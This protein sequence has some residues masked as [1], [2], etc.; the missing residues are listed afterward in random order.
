LTTSRNRRRFSFSRWSPTR[1]DCESALR[2]VDGTL[3]SM[4]ARWYYVP[5]KYIAMLL[6]GGGIRWISVGDL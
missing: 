6:C 4:D 3:P 1:W 5:T 2:D